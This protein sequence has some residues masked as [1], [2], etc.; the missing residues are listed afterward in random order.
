LS[1][2]GPT[3]DELATGPAFLRELGRGGMGVVYLGRQESLDRTVAVKVLELG[4]RPD[5]QLVERFLQEARIAASLTHPGIVPV[6][7]SGQGR[8]G[9][10]Q[11]TMTYMPGGSLRDLLET[12]PLDPG[13][14]VQ[15]GQQLAAALA[16]AHRRGIVHRDVKPSNIL[17]DA[18]GNA[19][20]ADFGIAALRGRSGLTHTGVQVGTPE[21]MAPELVEGGPASAATDTYAL[22]ITLYQC[23]AG[24]PPFTAEEAQAVLFQQVNRQPR[25][26]PD[27][28][29]PSLA[30]VLMTALA[31][32]PSDRYED[33]AAFQ[34]ALVDALAP[35]PVSLPSQLS[36]E[37]DPEI[38]G[39]LQLESATRTT[40]GRPD[41]PR[42]RLRIGRRGRLMVAVATGAVLLIGVL[43]L[44]VYPRPV[45]SD[46]V[47]SALPLPSNTAP[48]SLAP[49]VA[50]V[51]DLTP[52]PSAPS[53][54]NG[55]VRSTP[56]VGTVATNPST[57]Q[58]RSPGPSPSPPPP[59][60]TGTYD[61]FNSNSIDSS[62]WQT[63][64]AGSGPSITATNH[65]L[66]F[67]L[68]ASGSAPG[69][70]FGAT[71]QSACS[72]S[73]NFDVQVDY[74]TINWPTNSGGH[75]TLGIPGV[76]QVDRLSLGPGEAN[77]GNPVESYGYDTA[78]TGWVYRATS[79]TSGKLRMIRSGSTLTG[80][81]YTAGGWVPLHSSSMG[82]GNVRVL[83]GLF[84][85]GDNF[86]HADV[87]FAIDN[88]VVSS[89]RLVCP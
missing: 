32:D 15:I 11:L 48:P 20:L 85:F 81:V 22:G 71:L 13:E 58:P 74:Q 25:A 51:P 3:E 40:I 82:T 14:V 88:F 43:G 27:S 18:E 63:S 7:D 37:S 72:L 55:P 50:G 68:P 42:G 4:P 52:S 49:A 6:H 16:Y 46:K 30:G 1:R 23:L 78:A 76:V 80:L 79:D 83:F 60:T 61:A 12:R 2:K 53:T 69:S 54:G 67:F 41:R 70:N 17:F 36:N 29:P 47:L 59:F 56:G 31:K 45:A 8:D 24:T 65:R 9:T 38:R 84:G 19:Y 33:P 66:E 39:T 57:A 86:G 73:G 44:A 89:G 26:L 10:L 87:S 21:Y 34:T 5:L 64:I 77:A 28:V 62:K 35:T 75:I